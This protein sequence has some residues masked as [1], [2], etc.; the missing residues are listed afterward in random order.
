MSQLRVYAIHSDGEVD[1]YGDVS[2][3]FA[4]C[5]HV[6]ST[7]ARKH[8]VANPM[9]G[10]TAL[11][12]L[13]GVGALDDVDELVLGFTFDASWIRRENVPELSEALRVFWDDARFVNGDPDRKVAPSIPRLCD[14]LDAFVRDPDAGTGLCFNQTSVN[15]N[16]WQVRT[17]DEN[18]EGE[19]RRPFVFGQDERDLNGHI[20]FELK[21]RTEKY[22]E[23][24]AP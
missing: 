6:W 12:D 1:H 5:V 20:P 21:P 4:V 14:L 8:G 18:E 19:H 24:G 15:E 11:W 3:P 17:D 7:L 10:G 13:A 23:G 2:N 9:Y 22:S 16:P